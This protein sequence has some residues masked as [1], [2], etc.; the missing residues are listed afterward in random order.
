MVIMALDHVR[1]LLHLPAQTRD[2]TDLNTTT[3][4]IFLTRWITH[5]YAPIFVFLL[6]TL[7]YLPLQKR[8]RAGG[9]VAQ[10]RHLLLRRVL[11][12]IVLEITLVNITFWTDSQFWTMPLQVIYAIGGGFL[13]LS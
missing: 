2:P 1:D 4:P 7:A 6:G 12:L 11:V 9:A 8:R 3:I 5:L 10:T 13:L